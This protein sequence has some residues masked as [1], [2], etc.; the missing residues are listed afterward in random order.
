MKLLLH[1]FSPRIKREAT[2]TCSVLAGGNR[3]G[4]WIAV[5]D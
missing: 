4:V 2:A 1:G 3:K 5:D